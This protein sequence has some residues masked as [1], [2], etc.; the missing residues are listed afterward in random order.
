MKVI[1]ILG[2]GKSATVLIDYLLSQAPIN[3]W[4]ICIADQNISLAEAKARNNPRAK[5]LS[6]SIA[7]EAALSISIIAADLVISM[8]PP[9]FHLNVAKICLQLRKHLL[10][11]SYI[12]EEF[13]QLHQEVA[14]AG[15]SF[16]GEMGLDPG[17]DHMSAMEMIDAIKL[18]GG[19]IT[20]FKSHCGGLIA[21]ESDNNPWHYKISWNPKNIVLAGK[22]GALY[23]ENNHVKSLQYNQIFDQPKRIT[24]PALGDLAWYP[25][26]DSISYIQ[27]YH[28]EGI[29][30][31][32]RTTLRHPD[33]CKGWNLIVNAELTNDLQF[34]PT[35]ELTT[36]KFFHPIQSTLL[37]QYPTDESLLNMFNFLGMND[38]DTIPLEPATPAMVL[39]HIIEKKLALSSTD[40]DMIVMMHELEYLL[41]GKKLKK[42]ASLVVK[43]IDS[44]HTA[45]ATTV[46]LPLAIAATHILQG[47]ISR[48][49]VYIPIFE[50]VYKPIMQDLSKMGIC[51]LETT[52]D[53]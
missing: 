6:V 19:K 21:P 20:S 23:I 31:F 45:M 47:K 25:N 1:L 8:L 32:I 49:G 28:L 24:I 11:A 43:G 42:T 30:T 50:D 44:A 13:Q 40:R 52:S 51:F 36:K 39:Q 14:T 2:A 29:E 12:S 38:D 17:I 5:V 9:I 34:I 18:K 27:K 35:K 22:D 41:D 37:A 26:R 48:K 7:D 10:H 3:D 4:E 46:G 16:I 15:L 33:F 53:Y